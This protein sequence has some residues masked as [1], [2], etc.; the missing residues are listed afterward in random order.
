MIGGTIKQMEAYIGKALYLIA[1]KAADMKKIESRFRDCTISHK[2]DA[3]QPRSLAH[4][5]ADSLTDWC[6]IVKTMSIQLNAI[7]HSM[8]EIVDQCNRLNSLL[9]SRDQLQA[10]SFVSL[11]G[12]DEIAC[13]AHSPACKVPGYPTSGVSACQGR[14]DSMEDAHVLFDCLGRRFQQ[15]ERTKHWAF[16]GVYDGHGGA[17]CAKVAAKI[18]HKTI[19][20]Q[21][22]FANG[23]FAAAMRHGFLHADR[24]I[25]AQAEQER[26]RDGA[27]AVAALVVDNHLY[28]ANAGDSEMVLARRAGLNANGEYEYEAQLVTKVHKPT[29][30]SEI[31]RIER[32]GGNVFL[33]RVSGTLAV[34]RALGD[35]AFKSPLNRSNFDFVTA[36]PYVNDVALTSENEFMVVAC[37]GLWDVFKYYEVIDYIAARRRVANLSPEAIAKELSHD[38]IFKR[39]SRDNVTVVIVFLTDPAVPPPPPQQQQQSSPAATPTVA[40]SPSTSSPAMASS[41][42]ETVTTTST[43]PPQQQPPPQQQEAPSSE[44][45]VSSPQ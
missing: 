27:T 28:V 42:P 13:H 43:E 24:K 16:Y 3:N 9:P 2:H 29:D 40:E 20:E 6:E 32:A 45:V 18:L 10:V 11:T 23:N 34:S 7:R 21:E 5:L 39:G 26:W 37:D 12:K 38:A 35:S 30:M 4:S 41:S 22:P 17:E 44:V 14:R 19:M 33:G 15:L 25:L 31:E 1:L 36:E 8:E